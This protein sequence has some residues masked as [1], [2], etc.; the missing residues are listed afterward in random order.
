MTPLPRS[1]RDFTPGNGVWHAHI[2]SQPF[3]IKC[4]KHMAVANWFLQH[5]G[6]LGSTLIL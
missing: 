1:I 4:S 2:S 6:H 5:R 3:G